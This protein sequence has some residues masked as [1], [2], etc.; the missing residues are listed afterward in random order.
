[1]DSDEID[2]AALGVHVTELV[3]AIGNVDRWLNDCAP[4]V[5]PAL[6]KWRRLLLGPR[7]ELFRVMQS[8]DSQATELRQSNPFAGALD[9]QERTS[10]LRAFRS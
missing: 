7:D 6:E 4:G 10:V 9:S 2:L 1:L 8:D 5:R 3:L